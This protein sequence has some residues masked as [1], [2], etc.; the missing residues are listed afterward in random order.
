MIGII[1]YGMGNIASVYNAFEYSGV[2]AKILRSPAEMAACDKYVLPGV[3]AF[4]H[5]MANLNSMGFSEG[6]QKYVARE[7]RPLLGICLGMQLLATEGTE[8]GRHPGLNLIPGIV[9]RLPGEGLRLPHVGWNKTIT[10]KANALIQARED[11]PP[12][13]YY[14]H[15]YHFKPEDAACVITRCEYGTSFVSGVQKDNIFAFQFH[16]EKSQKAGLEILK[17]FNEIAIPC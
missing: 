5:G 1:H 2:P 8:F 12:Y 4:G 11:L 7:G 9:E 3:G 14:V 17:N 10:V 15:S 6:L 16:P 13:Y